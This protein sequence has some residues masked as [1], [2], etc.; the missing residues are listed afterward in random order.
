[1]EWFQRALTVK[2]IK[3]NLRVVFE[4]ELSSA[5]KVSVEYDID[6]YQNVLG[7][8]QELLGGWPQMSQAYVSPRDRLSSNECF[9]DTMRLILPGR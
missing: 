2:K 3:A 6:E 4:N 8:E 5:W 7:V 1:M 9:W